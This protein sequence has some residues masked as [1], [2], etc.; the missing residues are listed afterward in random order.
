MYL[1]EK[2][3]PLAE[4][5]SYS[6]KAK[7]KKKKKAVIFPLVSLLVLPQSLEYFA[8]NTI[9]IM[10]FG[11]IKVKVLFLFLKNQLCSSV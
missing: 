6:P 4:S 10:V 11:T 8:L 1:S 5:N 2:S 7:K 9:L 3:V